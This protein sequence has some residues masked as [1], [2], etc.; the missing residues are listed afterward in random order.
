MIAAVDFKT[1]RSG[2]IL[3]VQCGTVMRFTPTRDCKGF[4][5]LLAERL[6]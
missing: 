4:S 3:A 5:G 6:K 2:D 1:L